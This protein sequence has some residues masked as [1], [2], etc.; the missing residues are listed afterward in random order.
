VSHYS[1]LVAKASAL[2]INISR[3]AEAA[4]IKAFEE[5]EKAM[6][7]DE[8]CE[9][10]RLQAKWWQ[11]SAYLS[12]SSASSIPTKTATIQH[13]LFVNPSRRGRAI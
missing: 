3:N 2:G 6:I 12:P 9:A 5:A 4:I 8:I 10:A 1:D 11:S 13:D 7:G